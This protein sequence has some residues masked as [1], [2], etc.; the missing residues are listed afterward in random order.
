MQDLYKELIETLEADQ[1]I[2]I[3]DKLNKGLIIKIYCM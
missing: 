3:D 1:A 2:I